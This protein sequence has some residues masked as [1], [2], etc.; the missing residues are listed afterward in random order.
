MRSIAS[1]ARAASAAVGSTQEVSARLDPI[2]GT[3]VITG[4]WMRRWVDQ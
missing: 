1:A 3:V 2:L 4:T